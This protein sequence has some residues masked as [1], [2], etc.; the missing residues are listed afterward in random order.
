MNALLQLAFVTAA[1][2]ANN[3]SA[4]QQQQSGDSGTQQQTVSSTVADSQPQQQATVTMVS[5]SSL[6][7]APASLASPLRSGHTTGTSAPADSRSPSASTVSAEGSAFSRLVNRVKAGRDATNSHRERDRERDRDRD[8]DRDRADRDSRDRKDKKRSRE[9]RDRRERERDRGAALLPGRKKRRDVSS[10]N[11]QNS[12]SSDDSSDRGSDRKRNRQ[13]E[14]RG[15]D[16][17]RYSSRRRDRDKRDRR[18]RE[19]GGGSGERRDKRSRA[20]LDSDSEVADNHNQLTTGAVFHAT[21]TTP[22][23]TGAMAAVKAEAGGTSAFSSL[24]GMQGLLL[25]PACHSSAA[26]LTS[27]ALSALSRPIA[28]PVSRSCTR[29]IA[30]AYMV[31]FDSMQQL[32]EPLASVSSSSSL[33]TVPPTSSPFSPRTPAATATALNSAALSSSS[34]TV[35]SSPSSF[36]PSFSSTAGSCIVPSQTGVSVTRTGQRVLFDSSLE[37]DRRQLQLA[38]VQARALSNAALVTAA[39]GGGGAMSSSA[40]VSSSSSASLLNGHSSV[41]ASIAG[42]SLPSAGPP[43]TSAA[44][45]LSATNALLFNHSHAATSGALHA[46]FTAEHPSSTALH[47]VAPQMLHSVSQ[48]MHLMDV[49][50]AVAAAAQQQQQQHQQLLLSSQLSQQQQMRFQAQQAAA[51]QSLTAFPSSALPPA[52]LALTNDYN[53][54]LALLQQQQMAQQQQLDIQQALIAQQQQQQQ[55]Q[56]VDARIRTQAAQSHSQVQWHPTAGTL[57]FISPYNTLLSASGADISNSSWR[58]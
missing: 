28:C 55:Q 42:S 9:K 48:P 13:K 7:M 22:V 24:R 41:A 16:G 36:S 10:D 39:T 32:V 35:A 23:T 38:T 44:A 40:S 6:S 1:E 53:A 29:H 14:Q 4:Q 54:Q 27:T 18:D 17:A 56:Q 45:V 8:R 50:T 37:L 49:N 47:S 20:R 58:Y 57:H 34:S 3:S 11:N 33:R 30:I 5:A 46:H 12:R 52:P 25:Y 31:Y 21:L 19:T 51:A 43:A 26:P 15:K 2:P